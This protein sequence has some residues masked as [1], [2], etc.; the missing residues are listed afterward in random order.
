MHW[1]KFLNKRKGCVSIEMMPA[2]LAVAVKYRNKN[3]DSITAEMLVSDPA[4]S[5][6]QQLSE[7]VSKHQLSKFD[8]H[9]VL[10]PKKYQLLL[11]EA[12]PVEESEL[13]DAMKWKVRDLVN[14][15][16]DEVVIDV[17]LLP[18][19]G[20]KSN[21]SM[22]YVV[23][24]EL[25]YI[26]SIIELVSASGL[27]LQSIDIEEMAMRNLSILLDKGGEERGHAIVRV[28]EGGGS[29]ALFRA[30]HLYLSRQFAIN[31]SGGLFDE[32]PGDVLALEVQRSLDYYERQMGLAP[33]SDLYICGENITEDKI[34]DDIK[35]SLTVPTHFFD[36]SKIVQT[37][38]ELDSGMM[39]LCIGAFGG[40][41]R[42]GIM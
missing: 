38:N 33:P 21:K 41:Q 27:T 5:P 10:A 12:P 17:F 11:V 6:S 1:L 8:C 22:V 19:D 34:T 15:P 24:A 25:D 31:Y 13:R 4:V 14:W 30:G 20:T 3:G 35:R 26:K 16:I 37:N 29:V 42:Q 36:L 18:A 7:F 28:A 23:A 2:G 9:V 39:H 40:L 32:L